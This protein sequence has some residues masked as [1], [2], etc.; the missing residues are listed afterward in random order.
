MLKRVAA[1]L[2]VGVVAFLVALFIAVVLKMG[3]LVTLG[4]FFETWAF[5]IG[6]LAGAWYFITGKTFL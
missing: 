4:T 5:V 2:I 6:L 1:S 3:N